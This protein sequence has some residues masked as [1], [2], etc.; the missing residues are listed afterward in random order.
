MITPSGYTL[1]VHGR[2]VDLSRPCVMGILN[3]TPDSFFAGSRKQTEYDICRRA[4]EIVEQGGAIID[5]GA[6]STR[7]GAADVSEQEEMARLRMGL[8]AVRSVQPDALLS[9]DTFRP[10]VARMAVEEFGVGIIND[11]S[12]G[13]RTGVAFH[14]LQSRQDECPAIFSMVARLKVAYVLMSVQPSLETM[15]PVLAEEVRQLHALGVRDI[16]IDP[17]FGFGK[18]LTDN[19]RI[20]AQMEMLHTLRLPLLVGVSRKSMVYRLLECTPDEALSG[21]T[22]LHAVALAKGASVLR[23][24]DVADAVAAIQVMETLR[25]YVSHHPI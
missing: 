23:V 2:L 6:F 7:P 14:P 22:A 13:G 16:L 8:T 19:Y 17:G 20:M 10:D 18:T 25:Q 3:V 11:V 1:Q 21:T 15:L 9:V 4:E 24:H 5:V 12:E